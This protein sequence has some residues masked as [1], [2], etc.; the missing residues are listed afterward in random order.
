[1]FKKIKKAISLIERKI[2]KLFLNEKRAKKFISKISDIFNINLLTFAYRQI[3]IE[4]CDDEG[5]LS[6][7]KY[8][9]NIFLVDFFSRLNKNNLVIF[10]V[11]ANIGD[12]SF[13]LVSIFPASTIYS[14]E[15]NPTTYKNFLS[16]NHYSNINIY[17]MGLGSER[18]NKKLYSDGVLS[19]KATVIS[20]IYKYIHKE[21]K[22]IIE[23]EIK[24]DTIDNF[25]KDNSI[26]KINF[27][28]IDTEGLE[29]EILKGANNIIRNKNIDIIQFEFNSMNVSSRVF[30][31]DFYIL[32]DNYLFFRLNSNNLIPMLDYTVDNEIFKFQNI[33]AINKNHENILKEM[34]IL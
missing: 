30:L 2:I 19:Q 11:G 34:K 15:P 16:K 13:Q 1:M 31:I 32:L 20:D 8:L 6:G 14:F 12:Y 22:D 3:G 25:C 21:V 9:L 33:I 28:K 4:N 27:L 18:S 7:E 29:Y 23:Y 17:E 5:E 24:I 10:D 26:E